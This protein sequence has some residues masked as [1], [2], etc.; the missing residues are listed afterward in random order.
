MCQCITRERFFLAH[1]VARTFPNVSEG[2]LPGTLGDGVLSLDANE[3][4]SGAAEVDSLL[5]RMLGR[6]DLLESV[7][8]NGALDV[9]VEDGISC[10]LLLLI[11][12]SGR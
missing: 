8:R 6:L 2:V 3:A 10:A 11:C 9:T 7:S 5:F 4:D 1:I 12:A